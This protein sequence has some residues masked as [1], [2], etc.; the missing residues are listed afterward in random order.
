MKELRENNINE[1]ERK[2]I[3][4]FKDLYLKEIFLKNNP[5]KKEDF[6]DYKDQKSILVPLSY[7][8]VIINDEASE[9]ESQLDFLLYILERIPKNIKVIATRHSLQLNGSIPKETE[10]FL[11]DKYSNLTFVYELEKY[12]FLSQ[13]LTPLVDAVITLNST[14]A[15]HG[16]FYNKKVIALGDCE[17]NSVAD[18]NTLD[19]IEKILNN[20]NNEENKS[21]NVLYRL[22]TRHGFSL[23]KF[24]D[25]KWLTKRLMDMYKSHIDGTLYTRYDALPKV[26]END[27]DI[28]NILKNDTPGLKENFKPRIR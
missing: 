12:A 22:L 4:K 25:G 19:N 20:E 28:F 16:A 24:Q 3:L 5:I 18:D 11:L 13:W 6:L 15:Y 14:V 8:G 1:E 2:R 26:E 21:I 9:F 27:D 10:K 23:K 7:N 17:I